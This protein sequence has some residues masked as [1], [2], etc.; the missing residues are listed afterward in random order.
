VRKARRGGSSRERG[1]GEPR[2]VVRSVER[3]AHIL[4]ALL[5]A[6]PGGTRVS[7]LSSDLGLHKTTVVRLLN[8]LMKL[9]LVKKDAESGRYR[10]NP[11]A[12]MGVAAGM[13]EAFSAAD[14]VRGVLGEL[15]EASREL[16]LLAV[17][18]RS[19][20]VMRLVATHKPKEYLHLEPGPV[21]CAPMHAT[22][23][24]KVYLGG[25]SDAELAE[26]VQAGLEPVTRQTIRS[27]RRLMAEVAACRVRGYAVDRGE[28][29]VG[30]AGLAVP[31]RDTGERIVG[32]VMIATAA[33]HMTQRN[34]K[35]W[36]PVLRGASSQ[37]SEIIYRAYPGTAEESWRG[38]TAS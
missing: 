37:I 14:L 38:R 9:E 4:E 26:W 20:R 25:L 11:L 32:A 10:W 1:S 24:G 18:E 6:A 8:T 13:R 30:S 5:A 34:I 27:P 29:G 2:G 33:K 17:P 19:Q 15:A 36:V 22:A 28:F 12:W 31:L 23:P 21:Q 35:R 7:E 3:A 16:A